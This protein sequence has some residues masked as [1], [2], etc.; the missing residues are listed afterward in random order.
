[1]ARTA[2]QKIRT[3]KYE[4]QGGRCYY[5]ERLM[6]TDCARVFAGRFGISVRKAAQLRC[7]AEHLVAR[8]DGGRV[9]DGNIAAACLHCNST[10]HRAKRP[11][12]PD[13]FKRKAQARVTCGRWFQL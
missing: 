5:C 8:C 2:L 9:S 1:M 10:R 11:L 3:Q 7:T 12:S 4:A 6:W 13:A